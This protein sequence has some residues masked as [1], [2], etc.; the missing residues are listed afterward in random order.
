ME[1]LSI[2]NH[3]ENNS[4]LHNDSDGDRSINNENN[5]ATVTNDVNVDVIGKPN[6]VINPLFEI[7]IK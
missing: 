5:S 3:H 2:N 7:S 4:V 1:Q 6:K